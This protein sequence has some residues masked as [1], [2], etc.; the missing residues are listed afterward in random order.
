MYEI[1]FKNRF[2]KAFKKL[3]KKDK[4]II[5]SAVRELAEDP[6]SSLN[7]KKIVGLRQKAYRLRVGKYRI[8]YFVI[9]KKNVLEV[10]DLFIKKS[11]KDR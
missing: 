2:E 10:L 8:L 5:F 6:F 4:Q 1:V 3:I 11:N 7:V 9:T